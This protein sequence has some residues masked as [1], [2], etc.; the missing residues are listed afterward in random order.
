MLMN[1]LKAR[2]LLKYKL[3]MV[4]N[5]VRLRS[6]YKNKLFSTTD[7]AA[8]ARHKRDLSYFRIYDSIVLKN[9][10]FQCLAPAKF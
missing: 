6:H 2:K 10:Y 3:Y 9:L 7:F 8:M 1:V 5:V 4:Q